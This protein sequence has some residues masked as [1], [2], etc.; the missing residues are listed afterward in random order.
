MERE[1]RLNDLTL[2]PV[3]VTDVSCPE[4]LDYAP[5]AG[6]CLNFRMEFESDSVLDNPQIGAFSQGLREAIDEGKLYAI[7][8]S[9]TPDT[10]I[11]GLGSPG[12]GINYETGSNGAI[13][14]AANADTQSAEDDSGGLSSAAIIFIILGVIVIPVAIVAMYSRYKKEQNK[15]RLERLQAYSASQHDRDLTGDMEAGQGGFA[16]K[17]PNVAEGSDEGSV[18]SVGEGRDMKKTSGAGSSLAA[19]GAAGAMVNSKNQDSAAVKKE[20]EYLV[21]E[22]NAPKS[23]DELLKAYAGR[24]EELL[25]HLRKMKAKNDKEKDVRDEVMKLATET[26]APKSADEMLITYKGREEELLANLRKM[27]SRQMSHEE[28]ASKRAEVEGLV[29]ETGAPKGAD[30]LLETYEGREDVLIAN[31][32][33]MKSK[34]LGESTASAKEDEKLAAIKAEVATLAK[35]TNAP[36]STD[37]MLASY[38]GRE[39]ELLKNLRKMKTKQEKDAEIKTEVEALVAE[40]GAPKTAD[41]MLASY[42]G[43]EDELLK[44]LRKM[45]SKKLKSSQSQSQI[46]SEKASIKAEVEQLVKDTNAPKTADELLSSYEGRESELVANLQKMKSKQLKDSLKAS[47]K[48]EDEKKEDEK[49][50]VIKAEVAELAVKTGA[51]KPADEMLASY[52]GREEELLKNLRKMH[53]KQLKASAKAEAQAGA[54]SQEVDEKAEI[55]AEVTTLVNALNPGKTAEEMLAAYEGKEEELLKNLRKMKSKQDKAAAKKSAAAAPPAAPA[56]QAAP[57]AD[58]AAVRA[59]VAALVEKTKPGKSA[60][61][62]LAAYEGREEELVAFLKK[63]QKSKREID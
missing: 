5:K 52:Q 12:A 11:T 42:K 27:K 2:K 44:N 15:E 20:V 16:R 21:K 13:V 1:R 53:S 22:T 28:K 60:E 33:K 4:N 41:E 32:Q 8:I 46:E 25:T 48:M 47:A 45:K 43:R 40:T 3:G 7:I 10:N 18:Y 24:E 54:A 59:E 23:A 51:P 36:K 31:L 57:A 26:N 49:L 38:S 62:L 63:L 50:A 56:P 58:K 30:E 17:A 55:K 6:L 61:D 29:A 35:E 37:E 14:G 39:E 19:M 34:Q 9:A